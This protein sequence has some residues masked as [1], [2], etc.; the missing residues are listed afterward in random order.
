MA[1]KGQ[2]TRCFYKDGAHKTV[3][4]GSDEEKAAKKDGWKNT[5][6]KKVEAKL[7]TKAKEPVKTETTETK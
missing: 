3:T 6:Q 2:D 7:E 1:A 5:P 4:I